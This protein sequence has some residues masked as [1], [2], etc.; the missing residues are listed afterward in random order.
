MPVK[1]GLFLNLPIF[2]S[3]GGKTMNDYFIADTVET[4]DRKLT[5]FETAVLSKQAFM[6][7]SE[8]SLVDIFYMPMMAYIFTLGYGD[9]VNKRPLLAAWWQRVS[10]RPSW[11][12]FGVNAQILIATPP[13]EA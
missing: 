4:L 13:S 9:L 6:A 12:E 7:G 8:F 11:K 10:A 2:L 3:L 5:V 1:P